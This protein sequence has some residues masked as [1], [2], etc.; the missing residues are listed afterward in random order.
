MFQYKFVTQSLLWMGL[1]RCLRLAICSPRVSQVAVVQSLERHAECT[2][3][4]EVRNRACVACNGT[5][6]RVL[7]PQGL[8]AFQL[9]SL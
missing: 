6:I 9:E 2:V 8:R 4:L 7:L 5:I 1:G 3:S